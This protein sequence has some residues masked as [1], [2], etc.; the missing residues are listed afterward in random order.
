[1]AKTAQKKTA[2]ELF[3]LSRKALEDSKLVEIINHAPKKSDGSTNYSHVYNA[4]FE[5]VYGQTKDLKKSKELAVAARWAAKFKDTYPLDFKDKFAEVIEDNIV[6]TLQ[7]AHGRTEQKS[8]PKPEPKDAE[9]EL[10]GDMIFSTRGEKF[11]RIY[12][13]DFLYSG[14]KMAADLLEIITKVK[15]NEEKDSNFPRITWKFPAHFTHNAEE[16]S[17]AERLSALCNYLIQ[18]LEEKFGMQIKK[19]CENCGQNFPPYC[20]WRRTESLP[21]QPC[22]D[23]TPKEIP[24]EKK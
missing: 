4:A 17:E 7:T 24:E 22:V 8:G 13:Q 15:P 11:L 23:W 21:L 16:L 10:V 20:F 6:K 19:I 9:I 1:M 18:I 2:E 14:T 3:S 5:Y 12:S